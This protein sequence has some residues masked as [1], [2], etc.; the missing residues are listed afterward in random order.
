VQGNSIFRN[1]HSY[2]KKYY[3]SFLI[4][5]LLLALT[6]LLTAFLFYS[7]LEYIGH[8]NKIVR[9]ILFYSYIILLAYVFTQ[10][11]L[12]PVLRIFV[13]QWQISDQEAARKIGS[14]FPSVSDKLLNILQ[15]YYKHPE[16]QGLVKASISQK[17]EDIKDI[18]FEKAISLAENKKYLKYLAIPFIIVLFL[19]ISFPKV[20]SDSSTRIV[21][22][23][24]EYKPVAPFSFILKNRDLLAFKN[25][26]YD[27]QVSIEGEI[28]PDNV[29]L[30]LGERRIK[31]FSV[32]QTD[33]SYSLKKVAKNI[34]FEFEAAGF[35]SEEY[36]LRVVNRPNIKNFN[37]ELSYPGYLRR[38]NEQLSNIGTLK[39]PEGTDIKWQFQT[40]FTDSLSIEFLKDK[41]I[42]P[43]RGLD[44]QLYI[45]EKQALKSS[46]YEVKLFNQFAGNKDKIMYQLEVIPDEFPQISVKQYTDTVLYNY[47]ILGGNISDDYGFSDLRL[48]Y[49]IIKSENDQASRESMYQ[50]INIDPDK[51]SQS[52]YFNWSLDSLLLED[53]DQIEY[54]LEVRDNDGIN[55][56]K[57]SKT[58]LYYFRIPDKKERDE[59]L[60]KSSQSAENQIDKSLEMAKELN[61][62]IEEVENRLKGKKQM[63]WQDQKLLDEMIRDKDKL[64]EEIYKLQELN[65]ANNMKLEKFNEL[66]AELIKKVDQL[67][68][69][70]DD[71]LDEE[72]KKL[73]EELKKLLEEKKDLSE[74]KS[75]LERIDFK[76][77]NFEKELE[78]TLELFKRMKF[79]VELEKAIEEM[80]ELQKKQEGLS[81]ETDDRKND[82]EQ[83]KDDQESLNEDFEDTRESLEELIDINQDLAF[84]KPM[85]ITKE[86]EEE[87]SKHQKEAMEQLENNKRKNASKSQQNASD[88][89]KELSESMKQ[90]QTS[91]NMEMMME[92]YNSLRL[93][94]DNLI[95]LSFN[96]EDIMMSFRSV[97]QSDPRFINLSQRQ[98]ALKDDSK[99]IEDSLIALSKRV[100]QI[101][102]FI[103]REVN[104]MNK[105]MDESVVALRERKKS[106]A[107]G[108]QQFAMTSINNLALLLDDV[109]SSMQQQ[110][111]MAM[112]IPSPGQQSGKK[113]SMSELQK[114]LNEQ[115]SELKKS[116]K[117]GKALSEELAKLAAGQEEIR[118]KLREEEEKLNNM[119]GNGQK[120]G[121]IAGKM[122]QTEIDLVNKRLTEQLINRQ[123]EILTRLLQAEDAMREQELDDEREAES[124]RQL[125]RPIPPEFEDYLKLKEKEIELLRTVPPKLNPYYKKEVMEYFNRLETSFK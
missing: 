62:K 70:M 37:V 123:E 10:W 118:R 8:F 115:I 34:Q 7:L 12:L 40:L 56:R 60:K 1:I 58:G 41:E 111:A 44:D 63:N 67:Q 79:E 91:G 57:S 71:L 9:A 53:S 23:S 32:N 65:Q 22:Y 43:G 86:Q 45:A 26:D 75:L 108:K 100:F 5:S 50:T 17:S 109:L 55:G 66:D 125:D 81:K 112:G 97:N 64:D 106:Q 122:E 35:S 4:K 25:E 54:Y 49:K 21:N 105:Y 30:K 48:H 14:Y 96:Q 38:K 87:I 16:D 74:V 69:L 19:S 11:I 31:L 121:D 13:E 36:N 77:D 88:Q 107:V 82:L 24:K 117:Q 76:Q 84:P 85:Q 46:T 93:I 27:I 80:D 73:F 28:I 2:K 95:K 98:L 103:T 116:G 110:L 99:V 33:F 61:D 6:L 72:T 47:M 18:K 94:V 119:D 20:I 52:F 39:V 89:M 59:D 104:E 113:P 120:L 83:I 92:N 102:S 68:Q 78:R 101:S 3:K 51:T 15:L 90:M 114:Q 29:Y 124:A 42:F